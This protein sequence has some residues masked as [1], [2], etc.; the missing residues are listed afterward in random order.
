[1]RLH[2]SHRPRLTVT[3]LAL[4]LAPIATGCA[5]FIK[6]DHV[7]IG[8][9][10]TLRGL[11]PGDPVSDDLKELFSKGPHPPFDLARPLGLLEFLVDLPSQPDDGSF[12]ELKTGVSWDVT[13]DRAFAYAPRGADGRRRLGLFVV[14]GV[15][16]RTNTPAHEQGTFHLLTPRAEVGRVPHTLS[17]LHATDHPGL[18]VVVDKSQKKPYAAIVGPAD[19]LSRGWLTL[20]DDHPRV[21]FDRGLLPA[22]LTRAQ[23]ERWPLS[24][25]LPLVDGWPELLAMEP[26]A[27][28][29]LP[30]FVALAQA[31][32][33]DWLAELG[34]MPTDDLQAR[35]PVLGQL[36]L[37]ADATRARVEHLEKAGLPFTAA[38]ALRRLTHG[39]QGP[40]A[41]VGT[42]FARAVRV[43]QAHAELLRE[44]IRA[45]LPAVEVV[46]EGGTVAVEIVETS[47]AS[48]KQV[49]AGQ[50][51]GKVET[52][53]YTAFQANRIRLLER[54]KSIVK[55][56][57]ATKNY[58]V[59]R[60]E[61]RTKKTVYVDSARQVIP[62]AVK[63]ETTQ[64]LRWV[65]DP[66]L[67]ARH[68]AFLHEQA[69]VKRGLSVPAPERF[70]WKA[71]AAITQPWSGELTWVAHLTGVPGEP[72]LR[73]T[74][75]AAEEL[76][77]RQ[78][79]HPEKG[80]TLLDEQWGQ[81][82]LRIKAA[83]PVV[84]RLV[85]LLALDPAP[86]LASH[87][88]TITDAKRRAEE[89]AYGRSWLSLPAAPGDE[90]FLEARR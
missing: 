37:D 44:L 72:P 6:R 46:V 28:A 84:R 16:H 11:A 86:L 21:L 2:R 45:R 60:L 29:L 18:F 70:E 19:L 33:A 53:A 14:T 12:V 24:R 64:E 90:R 47:T 26:T 40:E 52:A 51:K 85:E 69:E 49:G 58:G 31:R 87:L 30:S 65:D 32:R 1:M 62:G 43:P 10:T 67:K 55:D 74:V 4:A 3:L 42:P 15:R 8:P 17:R 89:G 75:A 23:D 63:K 36:A 59:Q 66:V 5:T 83:E 13:Y 9:T 80:N 77:V 22:M 56:L 73:A 34:A 39:R 57:E 41:L 50:R 88:A 76:G 79:D 68:E 38:T 27:K 35:Q 61:T 71:Y 48:G 20:P 82:M 54:E 25:L 81:R 78:N 7:V